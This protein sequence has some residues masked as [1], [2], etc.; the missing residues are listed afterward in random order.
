[1]T[2]KSFAAGLTRR[3]ALRGG[4]SVIAL[5]GSAFAARPAWANP[6]MALAMELAG[7][8]TP[9]TS[10]RIRLTMPRAFKSGD[11]VPL[12]V[13]VEGPISEAYY[14][15][16]IHLLAEANPLP[17]IASFHFTPH[18]GRARVVTRIRLAKSQHVVALAEMGDGSALTTRAHVEVETDGC[19]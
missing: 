14:V 5:A 8:R 6:I 1:M 12:T 7:G 19:A 10:D 4:A 11:A 15:K 17:E 3:E 9:E 18:S 16:H 13:E 2:R